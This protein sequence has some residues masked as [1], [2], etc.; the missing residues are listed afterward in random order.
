[1]YITSVDCRDHTVQHTFANV[2]LF[3]PFRDSSLA[4]AHPNGEFETYVHRRRDRTLLVNPFFS[5]PNPKGVVHIQ[6]VRMLGMGEAF[7]ILEIF[8]TPKPITTKGLIN[9]PQ[10]HPIHPSVCVRVC[11]TI[12]LFLLK[13]TYVS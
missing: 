3:E 9:N 8:K 10:K 12:C 11:G 5:P 6:S 4:F 13:A 2:A 7:V 1:M